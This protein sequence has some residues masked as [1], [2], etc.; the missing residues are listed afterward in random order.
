MNEMFPLILYNFETFTL[1]KIEYIFLSV[2]VIQ[3]LNINM[4]CLSDSVIVEVEEYDFISF[5]LGVFVF[6]PTFGEA[7]DQP[8][9]FWQMMYFR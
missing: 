2:L 4:T 9:V 7:L 5:K 8:L 3:N 1:N 6:T